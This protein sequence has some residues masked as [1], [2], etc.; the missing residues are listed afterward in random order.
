MARPPSLQSP[1]PR[2]RPPRVATVLRL[3]WLPPPLRSAAPRERTRQALRGSRRSPRSCRSASPSRRATGAASPDSCPPRSCPPRPCPPAAP[4]RQSLP[5]ARLSRWRR[6]L[7]LGSWGMTPRRRGLS[8]GSRGLSPESRGLTC[9]RRG[10]SSGTWGLT[11]RR[12]GLTPGS[13]NAQNACKFAGYS[14]TSAASQAQPR[15]L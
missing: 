3:T 14:Q 10:L 4:A 13:R 1:A 12:R 9:R 6:R 2:P 8:S 11:R 15:P 5:P 7:T